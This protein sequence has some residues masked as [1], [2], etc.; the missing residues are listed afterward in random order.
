MFDCAATKLYNKNL[1]LFQAAPPV[2]TRYII[3]RVKQDRGAQVLRHS[4]LGGDWKCS[5][6]QGQGGLGMVAELMP[7]T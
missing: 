7:R 2:V 5:V 4:C 3:S 6:A 1:V